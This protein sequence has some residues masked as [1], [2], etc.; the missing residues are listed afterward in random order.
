M[1]AFVYPNPDDRSRLIVSTI[2]D[3]TMDTLKEISPEGFYLDKSS[4]PEEANRWFECIEITPEKKLQINI[5]KAREQTKKRLR[6]ERKPLL[7][8]LDVEFQRKLET[9]LKPDQIIIGEKNRLRD[10]TRL[11]ELCSTVE[12]LTKLSCK[13]L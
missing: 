12:E 13:K 1:R 11:P 9:N 5:T 3:E 2:I 4:L 6:E 7:E 10:I 8:A